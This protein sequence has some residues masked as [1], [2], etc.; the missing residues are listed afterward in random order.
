MEGRVAHVYRR[1]EGKFFSIQKAKGEGYSV[2]NRRLA[3][4]FSWIHKARKLVLFIQKARN[5]SYLV[6]KRLGRRYI[7]IEN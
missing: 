6:Y 7:C 4:K 5:E 2:V 1:L 3:G